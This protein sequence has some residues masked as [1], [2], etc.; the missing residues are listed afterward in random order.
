[1]LFS[2]YKVQT[3]ERNTT[4]TCLIV[5]VKKLAFTFSSTPFSGA[6]DDGQDYA[7]SRS[8]CVAVRSAKTVILT[9]N[10]NRK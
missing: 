10:E 8:Y 3:P 2:N 7:N 9:T 4:S 1:M 6:T 5:C